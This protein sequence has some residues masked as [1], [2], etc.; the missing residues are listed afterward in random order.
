MKTGIKKDVV[1][2]YR[3]REREAERT[4]EYFFDFFATN[5][6]WKDV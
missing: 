6:A 3:E 4:R 2:Y 5:G 1:F